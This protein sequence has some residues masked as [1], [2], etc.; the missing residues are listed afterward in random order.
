MAGSVAM[1]PRAF[2]GV[3][4]VLGLCFMAACKKEAPEAPKID[5]PPDVIA[6]LSL[7]HTAA[8][9]TRFGR[10]LDQVSPGTGAQV[11]GRTLADLL[12]KMVGAP[13]L[14]GLDLEQPVRVI[15][16]NPKTHAQ[17]PIVLLGSFPDAEKLR[18]SVGT[19][20]V[21]RKD[22]RALVGAEAEVTAAKAWAFGALA[23]A[24]APDAPTA[25]IWS[26]RVLAAY[27]SDLEA[28][29]KSF[30]ALGMSGAITA[31]L[32]GEIK[33]LIAAGE[34]S[35]RMIMTFDST[36]DDAVFDMALVPRKGTALGRLISVQK[37]FDPK[38]LGALP[39]TDGSSMVMVGHFELGDLREEVYKL[40]GPFLAE[41][42]NRPFDEALHKG[43][44]EWFDHFNGDFAA[45]A[46]LEPGGGTAMTEIIGVDDGPA[47]QKAL[48][49]FFGTPGGTRKT[50]VM[51]IG[52]SFTLTPAAAQHGSAS[53]DT[54]NTKFDLSSM[55]QMQRDMMDR[56]YPN[57]MNMA[58]TGFGKTLGVTL[59]TQAV[60]RMGQLIDLGLRGSNGKGVL[61]PYVKTV[62]DDSQ[63]R[64][65]SS[66]FVMNMAAF[67]NP[68]APPSPAQSGLAM[69][70]GFADGSGHVR[71]SLPAKHIGEITAA[72]TGAKSSVPAPH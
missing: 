59:G 48:M 5:A 2:L 63:K 20:T 65:E 30:G 23:G 13:A 21:E 57:G 14:D 11:N 42:V 35:E 45:V 44:N 25:E 58:I 32:E 53:I 8:F 43:W 54:F 55:P 22:G 68:F 10:Y 17:H 24:A 66:V 1:R 70:F 6:T 3:L 38:L 27:R 31:V 28:M 26:D 47:A 15:V 50:Q 40:G 12:A 18:K 34:Q 69:S 39:M 67:M 16:F 51:G 36:G 62:L 46:G 9:A 71:M 41:I 29:P 61:S 19:L 72:L 37:P 56:M 4:S 33:V 7:G 49:A 64:K 60:D 52:M